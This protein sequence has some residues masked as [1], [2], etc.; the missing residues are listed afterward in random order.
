MR[1]ALGAVSEAG[2]MK[3][4]SKYRPKKDEPR[5]SEPRRYDLSDPAEMAR[6]LLEL[7]GYMRVS[8]L[9]G[10]DTL[11]RAHAYAALCEINRRRRDEDAERDRPKADPMTG[12]QP[13]RLTG[14]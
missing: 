8:L 2:G 5:M 10:T 12:L 14:I 13:V 11:G 6:L 7:E 3:K 9:D 4:L 1:G